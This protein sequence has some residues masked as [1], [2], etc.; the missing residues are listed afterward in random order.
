MRRRAIVIG[1]VQLLVLGPMIV[2]LAVP[3]LRG[4]LQAKVIARGLRSNDWKERA[5][6][7]ERLVALGRPAIDGVLPELVASA[8]SEND[9]PDAIV[10]VGEVRS[11]ANDTIAFDIL[12]IL[13]HDP[14]HPRSGE[15]SFTPGIILERP[16]GDSVLYSS[17]G[18]RQLVRGREYGRR[19]DYAVD[20]DD[21]AVGSAVLDA[22]RDALDKPRAPGVRS[23]TSF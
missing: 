23:N 18:K 7:R 21:P 8:F 13:P 10:F 6:A 2:V 4:A 17:R 19:V 11:V 12:E 1:F 3:S 16:H 22:V 9:D 5:R 20:L 15:S 14:Q